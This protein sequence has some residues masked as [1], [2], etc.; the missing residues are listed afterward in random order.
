MESQ[1]LEVN[2]EG[3]GIENNPH[4]YGEFK[5]SLTSGRP[6]LKEMTT[7]TYTHTNL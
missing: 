4:L 7:A 2:T 5:T 3:S 6:C 1:N